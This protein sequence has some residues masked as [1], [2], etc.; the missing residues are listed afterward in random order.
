[1]LIVYRYGRGFG[2]SLVLMKK[3]RNLKV[4]VGAMNHLTK[5]HGKENIDR[6]LPPTNADLRRMIFIGCE[7]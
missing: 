2:L 4:Q 3:L 6:F 1:M 7:V 5:G